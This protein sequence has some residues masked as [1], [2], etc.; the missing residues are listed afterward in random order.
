MI[1]A[2]D[3]VRLTRGYFLKINKKLKR[4]KKSRSDR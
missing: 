4:L 3:T 1:L 2:H